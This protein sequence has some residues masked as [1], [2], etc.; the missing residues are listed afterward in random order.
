MRL[1]AGGAGG[2]ARGGEGD[3]AL[4]HAGEAVLHLRRWRADRHGAGDVGRAVAIL[5]AGIDEIE[6]ARFERALGRRGGV[7][8]HHRSVGAGAGDGVEREIAQLAGLLAQRLQPVGH[9]DLA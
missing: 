6:R 4:Q 7:V 5:R 8:V 3:V 2:E 9:F 1:R